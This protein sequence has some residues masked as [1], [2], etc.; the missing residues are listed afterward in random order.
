MVPKG[1]AEGSR[2]KC[3]FPAPSLPLASPSPLH[4]CSDGLTETKK[5]NEGENKLK[6]KRGQ[7]NG[8][9]KTCMKAT[10][11]TRPAPLPTVQ[12]S[13]KN[14]KRMNRTHLHG[15]SALQQTVPDSN[16]GLELPHQA[17]ETKMNQWL[18]FEECAAIPPQTS[19]NQRRES[20]R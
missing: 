8:P 19:K 9:E 12:M 5:K 3:P 15:K 10:L 14:Y 18:Q 11:A 4:D 7:R 6:R 20:T 16:L 13:N 1:G 2:I 17:T